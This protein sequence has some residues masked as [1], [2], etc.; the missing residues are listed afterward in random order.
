MFI[1]LNFSPTANT[2]TIIGWIYYKLGF[3]EYSKKMSGSN[4]TS[5]ES[6]QPWKKWHQ[7]IAM[8]YQT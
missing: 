3:E 8:K 7:T 4:V 6:I 2:L 1:N 5:V